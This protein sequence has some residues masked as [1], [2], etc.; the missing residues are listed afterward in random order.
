MRRPR[1]VKTLWAFFLMLV[2]HLTH[3]KLIYRRVFEWLF[4]G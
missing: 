4:G 1:N 2:P 3:G